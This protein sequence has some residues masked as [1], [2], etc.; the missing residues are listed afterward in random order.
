MSLW[1]TTLRIGADMKLLVTS[2]EG[3]LAKRLT[4]VQRQRNLG[5]PPP[6]SPASR[7]SLLRHGRLTWAVG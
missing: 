7:H 6:R 3:D 1:S 5:L 2:P 4:Y